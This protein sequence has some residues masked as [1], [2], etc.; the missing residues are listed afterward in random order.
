LNR[1][2]TFPGLKE[3]RLPLR[4]L[5]PDPEVVNCGALTRELLLSELFGHE[6]VPSRARL[7]LLQEIEARGS[8]LAAAR[9]IGWSYHHA[10]Q[11]L[12]LA[13]QPYGS[14]LVILRPGKGLRRG[15]ELT[16]EGRGL[17]V[18]LPD[19]WSRV[20]R[21]AGTTGPTREEIAAR[22]RHPPRARRV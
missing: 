7:S 21:S 10:W 12:R 5:R 9:H 6:R 11:Y 15:T 8:L 22:G 14:P 19:T 17:L 4:C 1:R 2:F 3:L 13:E 16:V 20:N 18:L